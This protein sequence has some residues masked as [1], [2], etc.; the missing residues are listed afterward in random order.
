MELQACK[1]RNVYKKRHPRPAP[2][3]DFHPSAARSRWRHSFFY[4]W[5]RCVT[6][7]GVMPGLFLGHYHVTQAFFFVSWHYWHATWSVNL[8]GTCSC[9][10]TGHIF[11]MIFGALL[12][13]LN[14]DHSQVFT[15]SKCGVISYLHVFSDWPKGKLRGGARLDQ[16]CH[17]QI[18]GKQ[19]N[20]KKINILGK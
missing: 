19:K 13:L 2:W 16:R 9:S 8:Q 5:G 18:K 12:S 6:S 10:I 14:L 1:V 3:P 17:S 7:F 4:E 20:K 15:P 11:S